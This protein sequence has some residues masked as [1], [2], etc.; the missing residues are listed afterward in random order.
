[1]LV[2]AHLEEIR[3]GARHGALRVLATILHHEPLVLLRLNG[4]ELR[5]AVLEHL[6]VGHRHALGV[7]EL[8]AALRDALWIHLQQR[9]AELGDALL[10]RLLGAGTEGDHGDHRADADD[11]PEH[12]ERRAQLVGAQRREGELDDFVEHCS[13]RRWGCRHGY[14]RPG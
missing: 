14:A 4:D 9:G 12:G 2:L 7:G 13:G 8:H 6:H 11:D 10:H 1:M 3:C 5:R